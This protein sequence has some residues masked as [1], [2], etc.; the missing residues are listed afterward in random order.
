MLKGSITAVFPRKLMQK[1]QQYGSL[2]IFYKIITKPVS[3]SMWT[4]NIS[5]GLTLDEDLQA[6]MAVKTGRIYF[7]QE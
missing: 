3:I 2:N 5:H 6:V 7:F 4:E 1:S